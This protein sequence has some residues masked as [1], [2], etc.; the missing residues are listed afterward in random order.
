MNSNPTPVKPPRKIPNMSHYAQP[1]SGLVSSMIEQL[2]HQERYS[3]RKNEDDEDGSRN[4]TSSYRRSPIRQMASPSRTCLTDTEILKSPTEVLYAVSDK[5]G[6]S[7]NERY[8]NSASQTSQSELLNK[9]YHDRRSK[10][11]RSRENIFNSNSRSLDRFDDDKENDA[12]Q[13][14]IQLVNPERHS[15]DRYNH[16]Q[17]AFKTMINTATDNIQYR[18]NSQENLLTSGN[19]YQKKSY[20][21]YPHDTEH[22]KVP[23][24]KSPVKS[25]PRIN[26]RIHATDSDHSSVY[27]R[28]DDNNFSS[29]RMVKNI[30]TRR[31][32]RELDREGRTIRRD[33]NRFHSGASTS[34]DRDEEHRS[35]Y[36][37][38]KAPPRAYS[39]HYS[40]RSPSTSPT[41]PPRAKSS[42]ARELIS[43][44]VRRVSSRSPSGHYHVSDSRKSHNRNDYDS[45]RLARFTEYKGKNGLDSSISDDLARERGRSLPPGANKDNTRDFYQSSQYK[46]MH[47]LPPSPMRPAPI[48]DRSPSNSTLIRRPKLRQ[49][50]PSRS[51]SE[52]SSSNKFRSQNNTNG[53]VR[54]P[55]RRSSTKRQAPS[56]PGMNNSRRRVV[57][58]D[59]ED[60][61]KTPINGH[62]IRRVA[63]S[64]R[65]LATANSDRIL[66]GGAKKMTRR[67]ASMDRGLDSSYSE[68]EGLPTVGKVKYLFLVQR[69][70]FNT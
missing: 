38:P 65:G 62:Q 8:A 6:H 24:N 3:R 46:S 43:N 36:S 41:R 10:S 2:G 18:G 60:R 16:N 17:M 26:N 7:K 23:R 61:V 28:K 21:R 47:N 27:Y 30:E 22:Y 50:Q 33:R 40:I 44:V 55:I 54:P 32:N 70:N 48:L 51:E 42:P 1:S 20:G 39:N 29:A 4:I 12:F 52:G 31:H 15:P 57:S 5:Y 11:S 66:A 63:S 25:I 19:M 68:S 59:R 58:S 49:T 67:K 14:R 45:E 56:P 37:H 13:T 34:P 9:N 69:L 64:D 35:A 53:M